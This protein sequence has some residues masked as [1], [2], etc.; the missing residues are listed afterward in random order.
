MVFEQIYASLDIANDKRSGEVLA[1]DWKRAVL[2]VIS[3]KAG[4][5]LALLR[6]R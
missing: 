1:L 5:S 6:V 3:M 2:L 4:T